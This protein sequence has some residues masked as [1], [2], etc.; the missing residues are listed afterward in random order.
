M[1]K[2]LSPNQAF[3]RWT[4]CE[5]IGDG[6][7]G[8]V[9]RARRDD[10]NEGALKF[11][12]KHLFQNPGIRLKRFYHEVEFMSREGN[13]EG[14]LPLLDFNCPEKPSVDDRPWLVTPLAIPISK[15]PLAGVSK[16]DELLTRLQPL[17]ACLAQLHKEGKFH[18]DL[19]PENM[20]D[21]NG[22]S[23][24]GDFGLVD[25]PEKESVTEATEMMGPFYYIAP[26]ML[27]S[28]ADVPGGPADVY[29]FAKT[30]WVLATGQKFPYPGE[31]RVNTRA[32]RV[33]ALLSAR[34]CALFGQ[35][36]RQCNPARSKGTP[37]H[38]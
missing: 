24:L 30:I 12:K 15:I 29:S 16:F 5:E 27:Q 19:K 37:D 7:N 23:V 8:N 20:F 28:A 36:D 1:E 13:R 10:G 26:E 38:E 3:R 21:W 31:M 33:S 2:K 9:W 34:Q 4:L 11:L 25:Y 6:G 22:R 32:L 14:L 18:R 17:S 35:V